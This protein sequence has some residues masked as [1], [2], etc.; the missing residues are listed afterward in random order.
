MKQSLSGRT[1]LVTGA[2]GGLGEQFVAQ[3]LER[4][5]TK[6]F[7]AARSPRS[8]N[9]DRIVPLSLDITDAAAIADRVEAIQR[10]EADVLAAI[11][12]GRADR[13]WVARTLA[14]KGVL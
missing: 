12:A 6:V 5:A 8:W 3:A 1:V 4:G 10:D 7:A 13:S 2:N 14:A 11:A 9:D